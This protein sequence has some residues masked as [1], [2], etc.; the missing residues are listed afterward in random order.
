MD[1]HPVVLEQG[2]ET[3]T[4]RRRPGRHGR[5]RIGAKEHEHAEEQQDAHQGRDDI[6]L[7]R[8]HTIPEADDAH[9]RVDR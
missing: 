4:V 9:G 5:K 3:L 6:G 7:Q 8:P 2:V 1:H